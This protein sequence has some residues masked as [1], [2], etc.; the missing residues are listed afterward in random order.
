MAVILNPSFETP[1][2]L[3]EGKPANWAYATANMGPDPFAD[4]TLW[5][6][7]IESFGCVEWFGLPWIDD[8][9]GAGPV[10]AA[11]D[12][13]ARNYETWFMTW[14]DSFTGVAAMYD[15][16]TVPYEDWTFAWYD[17]WS[18]VGS[19]AAMYDA[20]ANAYETWVLS[21]WIDPF[22]AGTFAMYNAGANA[23]E[24]FEAW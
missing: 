1:D 24:D 17:P 18:A 10:S 16:A 20:G 8:W 3:G 22:P 14:L 2:A 11:Y 15:T 21:A 12:F 19:V 23:F 4:Y 7:G 5:G 13:G 6:G 9:T